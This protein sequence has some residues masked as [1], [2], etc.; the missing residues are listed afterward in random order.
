MGARVDDVH[1][2]RFSSKLWSIPKR[3]ASMIKEKILVNRANR[4]I[5]GSIIAPYLTCCVPSKFELPWTIGNDTIAEK[6]FELSSE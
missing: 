5:D 1:I 3:A 6:E 4:P 2:Q